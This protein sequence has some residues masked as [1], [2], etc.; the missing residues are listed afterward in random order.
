M[1][2]RYVLSNINL[3]RL[4]RI[5]ESQ[6]SQ[7]SAISHSNAHTP[8]KDLQTSM[9][10]LSRT[11]SPTKIASRTIKEGLRMAPYEELEAQYKEVVRANRVLKAERD[12]FLSG[13]QE[14]KYIS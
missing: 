7:G 3:N 11:K 5:D 1:A 8:N 2:H 6:V 13:Y 4:N 9:H 14:L 12:Q 10:S